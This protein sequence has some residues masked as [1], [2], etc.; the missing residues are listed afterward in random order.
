MWAIST[1]LT[2]FVMCVCVEHLNRSK[3]SSQQGAQVWLWFLCQRRRP[4][5]TVI[6]KGDVPLTYLLQFSFFISIFCNGT[7]LTQEPPCRFQT[8][9]FQFYRFARF[10]QSVKVGTILL[11]WKGRVSF[12]LFA[13]S[14]G[15][16]DGIFSILLGSFHR[17]IPVRYNW[18][19]FARKMHSTSEF[20]MIVPSKCVMH[21]ASWRS[22]QHC[23]PAIPSNSSGIA[24]LP[25]CDWA[26]LMLMMTP[27]NQDSSPAKRCLCNTA[28]M[29]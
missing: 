27:C 29:T 8:T 23:Q 2:T 22:C 15:Y 16:G 19:A 21:A 12:Q 25:T 13:S 18:G 10:S 24:H 5:V 4:D 17:P 7:W 20:A 1:C 3:T 28:V 6:S 11:S 9:R 14:S 26:H